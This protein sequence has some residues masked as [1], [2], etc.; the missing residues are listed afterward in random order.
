MPGLLK[1]T[2]NFWN[3]YRN[4]MK[5]SLTD[6]RENKIPIYKLDIFIIILKWVEEITP[7]IQER[8]LFDD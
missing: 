2:Y 1:K 3:N 5:D 7:G 4:K 6:N 8:Q